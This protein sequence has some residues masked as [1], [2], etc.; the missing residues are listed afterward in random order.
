MNPRSFYGEKAK[1]KHKTRLL[2]QPDIF[3]ESD[4]YSNSKNKLYEYHDSSCET[5]HS[6]EYDE[7]Q[8]ERTTA[9]IH[10]TSK[11]KKICSIY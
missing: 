3:K 1:G 11:I 5:E 4:L 9:P 6:K 10:S 7:S 2:S 8:D